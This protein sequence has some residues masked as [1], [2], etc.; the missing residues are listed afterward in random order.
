MKTILGISAFYHDSAATILVDGKIIAAAQEER[1]T[2][3]K[4]DSSYPYNA[5]E[6]VLNFA[7]IKLSEVDQII[8]FEKPFL[9]F[10]RL[11]ETYV[12]FAPRGFA[13][14][15]KAMPIWL[16]DKLFQKKKLFNELKS[17]DSNFND[18]KKIYFS[19]HHLSHAA[20][21]FFPSPFS[22]AVILTADGVGEWATT[23]VAI[24]K[25]NKLE[26]KKEIHF[27][28][29]LGLLY[30]AFTYYTGFK[31][32]SGEYK[33]MGLAPFGKP[34]Y[35][36]LIRDNLIDIKEDGSFHLDQ[37]YFNYATDFTM[38]NHKFDNL[39]GEKTRDPKHDKLNQFHMNI[40][41]SIQ[42][43]T[44]D[45]MVKLAKSLK[46]EFNIQNLCLAGGVALNCVANGKILKEKIFK[47][48]WVQ[49]A[50]GDAGG[51]LGAALALWYGE[52]NNPRVVNL[53]DDMQ[54]SYLGPEFSND[55]IKEQLDKVGAKYEFLSEQKLIDK[56]VKDLS[57]EE[58]I[59]WF[60]GRMEFG[61]RALGARSILA[62]PRSESMQK[63]LNLKI[64]FR[65]SFRPFAPS[66]LKEDLTEWFDINT[67]SPYMLMVSSIKKDKT[68]KIDED[69]KFLFGIDLLNLKRSRV[70]AVTHVDYSARIQTVHK[71]TNEK[72][73]NLLKRF[74]EKT[75]CPILVN[76][77]FNVRGEPI[78]NTPLD[79]FNCFMGTGL[80]KLVIGN[81]YLDKKNQN[82]NLK[83]NYENEFELD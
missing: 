50:A 33:L 78:V 36:D 74:K 48:I 35:E 54:G 31:V 20:S 39:F 49:P 55:E 14:F 79:A 2:R 51:S 3:K 81:F 12:A 47:N 24:G 7:K 68:F 62:D 30:S 67:D 10:E 26:I 70:P 64:K 44:E 9:K 65:E 16:K 27:P 21:A 25:G 4:H 15:S 60:Q 22:E 59:G 13:S 23:T 43:V 71:E 77:S 75:N 8:F 72:Y 53:K 32:N 63:N 28:H 6:F 58:A 37:S 76:T 57:H 45:V 56:A 80:D 19:E 38:T 34:V 29:S 83:K 46:K 18:I 42:K 1:F 17:H 82:T 41:A 5:I 69:K 73:F 61:P 11:L 66:I 40:A 52:Q